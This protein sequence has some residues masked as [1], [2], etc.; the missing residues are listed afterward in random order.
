MATIP[1]ITIGMMDFIISSGLITAIAAIPVPA[2][3]VPY[4]AP[5]AKEK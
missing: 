3:A 2:L 5:K 4:A 1:A